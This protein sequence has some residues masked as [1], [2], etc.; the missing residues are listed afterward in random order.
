VVTKWWQC[1]PQLP[2]GNEKVGPSFAFYLS[3]FIF[4]FMKAQGE[5]EGHC[6]GVVTS[7]GNVTHKYLMEMR[8]LARDETPFSLSHA[9][10]S[11]CP[12]VVTR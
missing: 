5:I 11:H 1:H 6:P 12:G 9:T 8:R 4:S 10:Q 3:F 7:G 2:N